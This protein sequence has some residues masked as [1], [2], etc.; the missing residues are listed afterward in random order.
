MIK[1]AR[2]CFPQYLKLAKQVLSSKYRVPGWAQ[3]KIGHLEFS[4]GQQNSGILL[5]DEQ[6]SSSA[7]ILTL[8]TPT[9]YHVISLND[10]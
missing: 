10:S 2:F 1:I 7:L 5:R 8:P 3:Y 9:F 6:A 4:N